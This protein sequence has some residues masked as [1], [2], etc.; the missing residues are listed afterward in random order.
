VPFLPPNP[1]FRWT[2]YY[3]SFSFQSL[4][5]TRP[6]SLFLSAHRKS[7][8]PKV[9]PTAS[10]FLTQF[11]LRRGYFVVVTS[12]SH[13]LVRLCAFLL[14]T[15]PPKSNSRE[16]IRTPRLFHARPTLSSFRSSF[17]PGLLVGSPHAVRF[18]TTFYWRLGLPALP[19]SHVPLQGRFFAGVPTHISR[20]RA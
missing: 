19:P 5:P 8:A 6:P 1:F 18:F 14:C 13:M 4:P 15:G 2:T 10:L 17:K 16:W 12:G 7:Q 20:S 9:Y 11:L 3:P